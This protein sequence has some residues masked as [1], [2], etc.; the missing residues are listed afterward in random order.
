[1]KHTEFTIG[2]E[3]AA[4]LVALDQGLTYGG[5]MEGVPTDKM[6]ARIIE[7]L[8]KKHPDAHLLEPTQT[9]IEYDRPYP[10]GA[11]ARM[12]A[13]YCVATFHGAGSTDPVLYF[14][15]LK[16]FWFQDAWALPVADDIIA[17]LRALEWDALATEV[18]V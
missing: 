5:L 13:N 8:R 16:V 3:K 9:P 4:R 18:E 1:M 6:N 17:E 14:T 15:H 11:P 10:F 7:A 12:P 2:P